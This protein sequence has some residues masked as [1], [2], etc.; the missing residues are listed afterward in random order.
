MEEPGPAVDSGD[1][2][3]GVTT[4]N[5]ER[6]CRYFAIYMVISWIP[7]LFGL[8]HFAVFLPLLNAALS[9]FVSIIVSLYMLCL[10]RF[11]W[12]G[13]TVI[14]LTALHHLILWLLP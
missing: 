9:V 2:V 3:K 12:W 6:L 4:H 7:L 14:L 11:F 13:A 10:W 8:G 1:W 5:A